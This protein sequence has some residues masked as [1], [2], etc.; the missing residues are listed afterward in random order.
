MVLP[1]A[2]GM[3]MVHEEGGHQW[4]VNYVSKTF[5]KVEARYRSIQK[6][7]LALFALNNNCDLSFKLT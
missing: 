3:V 5:Y 1:R 6:E 2:I 7:D 4:L